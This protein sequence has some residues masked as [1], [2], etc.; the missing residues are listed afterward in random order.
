MTM[1]VCPL[2]VAAVV[3]RVTYAADRARYLLVCRMRSP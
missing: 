1:Y 3:R 2:L